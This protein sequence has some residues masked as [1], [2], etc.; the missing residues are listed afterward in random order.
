MPRR[1]FLLLL[2]LAL[3]LPA[4]LYAEDQP[5]PVLR[6]MQA[7]LDRS[8]TALK[9]QPVPPYFLSYEITE[10]HAVHV[11][12]SFGTINASGENR[13]RVLDIDLR[14]GDYALDNTHR[15]RGGFLHPGV[16]DEI[17][18]IVGAEHQHRAA[19]HADFAGAASFALAKDLE[20]HVQ[21][22]GLQFRR[23][24]ESPAFFEKVAG[25]GAFPAGCRGGGRTPH[26]L[27]FHS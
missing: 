3:A 15:L 6:A 27:Q 8:L 5:S 7:E 19:A 11:N 13:R 24:R 20:V 2:I 25:S 14:V 17:Q 12:G 1:V 10:T 16:R 26:C 18:I 9:A 22:G 21:P 4:L 23:P